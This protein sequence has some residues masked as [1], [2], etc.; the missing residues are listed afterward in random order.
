MATQQPGLGLVWRPGDLDG[1]LALAL[2][3]LITILLIIGL[4]RDVLGY[5]DSLVFGVILPATGIRYTKRLWQG[6]M[7]QSQVLF[8]RMGVRTN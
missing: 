4:C 2:N 8:E 1:F 6:L 3:N 7:P 5:P